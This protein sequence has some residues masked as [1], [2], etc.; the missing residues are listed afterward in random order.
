[1]PWYPDEGNGQLGQE[2]YETPSSLDRITAEYAGVGLME[3]ADMDYVTYLGLRHD[4]FISHMRKTESG[5]EY[6]NTAWIL[7]QTEPDREAA[8]RLFGNGGGSNG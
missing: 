3:L 8:R 7:Q 4:A 1:M 6:L 5:R 2:K